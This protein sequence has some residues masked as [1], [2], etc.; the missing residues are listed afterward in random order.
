VPESPQSAT[1]ADPGNP[2]PPAEC[3]KGFV[4]KKGKCVKKKPRHGKAGHGKKGGKKT[5]KGKAKDNRRA[6]K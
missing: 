3:K 5:H 2:T 1:L 4:R 6:G